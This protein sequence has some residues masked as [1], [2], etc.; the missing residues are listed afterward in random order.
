MP[1]SKYSPVSLLM[2]AVRFGSSMVRRCMASV[3]RGRSLGW[4]GSRAMVITGS[5]M[6]RMCSKGII[7]SLWLLSTRVSPVLACSMPR[8]AAMLPAL[9][10]STIS[11]IAPMY[12]ETCCTR[13]FFLASTR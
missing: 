8:S 13:W 7:V 1:L 6:Y 11:R 3:R 4:V 5:E 10:W 9:I 12:I 2:V